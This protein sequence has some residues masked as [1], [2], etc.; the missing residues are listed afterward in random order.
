[1]R[2]LLHPY[3][4]RGRTADRLALLL[5]LGLLVVLAVSLVEGVRSLQFS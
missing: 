5:L 1:M 4:K 2:R 3:F